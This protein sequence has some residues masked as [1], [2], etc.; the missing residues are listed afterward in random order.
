MRALRTPLAS[1][2]VLAVGLAVL[3]FATEGFRAF[4]S[5]S[6]RRIVVSEHPRE[7]PS[8]ALQTAAG[9]RTSFSKLHGRWLLVDFIYTRC[10]TYCLAQGGEFARLQRRLAEPIAAGQVLLV[11]VSF[12]P[13]DGPRELADYQ[14]RFGDRGAGWMAARA[15]DDDGRM[16][17]M[18]AFG[19]TAVADEMGGFVHNAAINLVDPAGRL[20]AIRDWDDARGAADY[21]MQ[22]LAP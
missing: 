18:R 9:E 1:L 3:A 21:V 13:R 16:A 7:V 6:A 15:L 8:V 19:V 20:V 5:E 11:S 17:L 10:E 22:R 2:A 4:T 14:R 12:D